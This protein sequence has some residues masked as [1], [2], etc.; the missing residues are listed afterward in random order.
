MEDEKAVSL[1]LYNRRSLMGGKREE[2]RKNLRLLGGQNF[3]RTL[4]REN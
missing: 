4:T 1:P 2:Q 3:S